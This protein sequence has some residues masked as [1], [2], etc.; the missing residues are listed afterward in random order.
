MDRSETIF[1]SK[2]GEARGIIGDITKIKEYAQKVDGINSGETHIITILNSTGQAGMCSMYDDGSVS[3][4]SMPSDVESY[5]GI[6][7]HEAIGHG[8]GK[9]G[10]EY[11]DYYET[12]NQANQ[13][14][15]I[16]A[17]SKG[18]FQNL[19]LSQ[20]NPPWAHFIGNS[21][22]PLVGTFEGGFYFW[23]GVWRPEETSSMIVSKLHYFNAPSRE[24]IVKRTLQAAGVT[25]SWTDFVAKDKSS[26]GTKAATIP[27]ANREEKLEQHSQPVIMN[28]KL[29]E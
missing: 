10:D 7:Q 23:K 13:E 24:Q 27:T 16:E 14:H 19:T 11:I 9:L 3:F 22:Y 2:F 28:R 1:S 25:Y 6:L 8:L 12:I 5:A 20:T 17:Q 18:W 29:F 4:I 21:S 15:L 26:S